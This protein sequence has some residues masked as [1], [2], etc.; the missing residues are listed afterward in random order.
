MN[1]RKT[2]KLQAAARW[3]Q[4]QALTK[5]AHVTVETAAELI[6]EAKV[7]EKTAYPNVEIHGP[8]AAADLALSDWECGNGRELPVECTD[9]ETVV[10][11]NDPYFGTFCGTFCQDHMASHVR[12]CW[13]CRDDFF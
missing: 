4:A 12:E 13:V 6:G 5:H 8:Q 9:C 10:H 1:N 11:P 7:R 3:L 2:K